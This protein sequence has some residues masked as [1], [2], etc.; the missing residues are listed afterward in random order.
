MG[1]KP[2]KLH[3]SLHEQ[4]CHAPAILDSGT[5]IQA[6]DEQRL[7]CSRPCCLYPATVNRT[8]GYA[9]QCWQ[10][11]QQLQG[12]PAVVL[13][14]LLSQLVGRWCLS[15]LKC[16][17]IAETNE[18]SNLKRF[19]YAAA[20]FSCIPT[21]EQCPPSQPRTPGHTPASWHCPALNCTSPCLLQLRMH[22]ENTR[23][24]F[25]EPKQAAAAAQKKKN[26]TIY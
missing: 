18:L 24:K 5:C 6:A 13:T 15:A 16:Q 11:V 2:L 1:Q 3:L 20:I 9:Q 10:H 21:S 17:Q 8:V 14:H 19:R 22:K 23:R 7:Q 4:P 25:V 12:I 26:Y